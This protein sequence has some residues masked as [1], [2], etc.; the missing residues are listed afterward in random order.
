M[1]KSM[2]GWFGVL[3]NNAAAQDWKV[4]NNPIDGRVSLKI[5]ATGGVGDIFIMLGQNAN[6]VVQ[7]YHQGVV[8]T[9]V[10]VPSWALGWSQCRWGY[11]NLEQL[12]ETVNNY[13]IFNLPL[14]NMFSDVDFMD[15]YKDFTYDSKYNYKQL[16]EFIANLTSKNMQWIPI[17]DA[18]IAKRPHDLYDGMSYSTYKDGVAKD[19]FLKAPN[20]EVATGRVWPT[21]AS[22]VDWFH[23]NTE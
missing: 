16:P 18:G 1:A 10:Q 9:P 7:M 2:N 11:K 13:T 19:V 14:D 5:R 12:N 4:E 15:N 22:F 23:P 21:D 3:I 20:G 17:V 6:E 8:G